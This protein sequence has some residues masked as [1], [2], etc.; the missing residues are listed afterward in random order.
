LL[1]FNE[2]KVLQR[3]N[4]HTMEVMQQLWNNTWIMKEHYST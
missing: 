1:N 3:N 2:A 4:V